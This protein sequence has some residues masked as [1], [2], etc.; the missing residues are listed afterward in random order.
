MRFNREGREGNKGDLPRYAIDFA[1]FVLAARPSGPDKKAHRMRNE[2]DQ[3]MKHAFDPDAPVG[4]VLVIG[5]PRFPSR[6]FAS[7]AVK[8]P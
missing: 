4:G 7:F 3:R 2:L 1:F 8:R 6:S 5:F